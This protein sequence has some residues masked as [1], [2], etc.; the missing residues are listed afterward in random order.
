MLT[1]FRM[2]PFLLIMRMTLVWHSILQPTAPTSPNQAYDTGRVEDI[3]C[4]NLQ[5]SSMQTNEAAPSIVAQAYVT[6]ALLLPA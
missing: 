2:L 3:I 5:A 1:T 6:S 4:F